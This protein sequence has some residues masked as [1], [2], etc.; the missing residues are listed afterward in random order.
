MMKNCFPILFTG[1]SHRTYHGLP[2]Y[3]KGYVRRETTT[4]GEGTPHDDISRETEHLPNPD[5][6]YAGLTPA[7]ID[8]SKIVVSFT[9]KQN[10]LF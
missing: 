9:L 1:V 4:T 7:Q 8:V 2:E 6:F 10:I 5:H 3:M